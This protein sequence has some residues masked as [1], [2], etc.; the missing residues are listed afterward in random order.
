MTATI[1]RDTVMN[2]LTRERLIVTQRATV[3]YRALGLSEKERMIFTTLLAYPMRW[4]VQTL[5]E[6]IGYARAAVRKY[7]HQLKQAGA[8]EGA[9]GEGWVPTPYGEKIG[10]WVVNEVSEIAAGGRRRFSKE[11]LDAVKEFRVK[12]GGVKLD[13]IPYDRVF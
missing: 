8:V 7:L 6:E 1:I 4:K 5:A 11:M 3:A 10:L 12:M 2:A 13:K 9:D